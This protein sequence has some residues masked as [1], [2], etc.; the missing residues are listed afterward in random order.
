VRVTVD[1]SCFQATEEKRAKSG[2]RAEKEFYGMV[3]EE[4]EE[5]VVEEV[6]VVVQCPGGQHART[7][8]QARRGRQIKSKCYARGGWAV[9]GAQ[10][11]Q[12]VAGVERAREKMG[13]EKGRDTTTRG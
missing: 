7:S 5:A 12:A 1:V 6:V 2:E 9:G 4:E 8:Q 3:V 13:G 11:K 10:W